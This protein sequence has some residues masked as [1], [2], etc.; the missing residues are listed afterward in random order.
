M[1]YMIKRIWNWEYAIRKVGHDGWIK[2]IPNSQILF[3]KH[4]DEPAKHGSF[5]VHYGWTLP[6]PENTFEIEE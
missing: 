4:K 6:C 1:V 3:F 2:K 5:L